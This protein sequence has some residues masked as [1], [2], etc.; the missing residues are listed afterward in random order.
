[1]TAPHPPELIAVQPQRVVL[2]RIRT[3]PQDW[4]SRRQNQSGA[5]RVP[6]LATTVLEIEVANRDQSS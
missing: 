2:A 5:Q 4:P 6:D 1:M 3:S